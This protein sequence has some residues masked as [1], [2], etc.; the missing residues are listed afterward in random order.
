MA[1][2]LA[3][4]SWVSK[5]RAALQRSVW[6]PVGLRAAGIAA[7]MLGLAAVGA[8]S[9]VN[10]TRG[11]PLADAARGDSRPGLSWLDGAAPA[12]SHAP[13][14]GVR[15]NGAQPASEPSAEREGQAP[16]SRA[17]PRF[18]FSL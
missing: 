3:T 4:P 7:L 6:M 10:A 9:V 17:R 14:V 13:E 5:A 15:S 16:S 8:S 11:D 2:H 12:G 18:S 1:T